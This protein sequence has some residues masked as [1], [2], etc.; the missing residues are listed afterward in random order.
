[1]SNKIVVKVPED[2]GHGVFIFKVKNYIMAEDMDIY[3]NEIIRQINSGCVLL[4]NNIELVYP[5]LY[6]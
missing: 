4:P 3:R 5:R 2:L 6:E 1:M